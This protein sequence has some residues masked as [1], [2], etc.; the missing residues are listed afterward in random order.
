MH[1]NWNLRNI[2]LLTLISIICGIIF[3]A[4]GFLYNAITILLTPM[5]LAP[6]ANDLLIGLWIM[7][8]P[9]ATLIFKVP[10]ASILSEILGSVVE[11]FIGGQWGASTLIS[12]AIQ[13]T[14]SEL[15]F[16]V[17]GYKN[18]NWIGIISTTITTTIIT[19]G[20]DWFKNGY[21][22]YSFN[23]LIL[24]FITRLLSVFVFGGILSKLISN[25]LEKSNVIKNN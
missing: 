2:I 8:A 25:M 7:A 22:A 19:F 1:S 15:G 11:M 5:G 10:G 18:Y 3:F 9:L 17:T 14:A 24:L 12:G 13:G 20:W 4:T 6:M 21:N 16:T 23:L